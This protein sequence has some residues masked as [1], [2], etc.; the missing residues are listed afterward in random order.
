M[1]AIYA[2]AHPEGKTNNCLL[3]CRFICQDLQG[4]EP[5]VRQIMPLLVY[6][7]KG[8][9]WCELAG[10]LHTVRAGGLLVLPPGVPLTCGA[11]GCWLLVVRGSRF[12]GSTVRG[13]RFDGS[14]LAVDCWLLA[15]I[16]PLRRWPIVGPDES[17][18]IHKQPGADKPSADC[19]GPTLGALDTRDSTLAFGRFCTA[20]HAPD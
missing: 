2:R 8:G 1:P 19:L 13:S 10:Q 5:K 16:A 3:W 9:G 6:C 11:P 18:S 20:A 17:I 15:V 7:V 4:G 12:D 14:R